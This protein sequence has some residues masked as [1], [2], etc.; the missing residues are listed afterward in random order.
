M[1]H[2]LP[3][4]IGRPHYRQTQ[5]TVPERTEKQPTQP[6]YVLTTRGLQVVRA[7][8]EEMSGRADVDVQYFANKA[9]ELVA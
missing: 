7:T 9:L 4:T 6:R 2:Q 1:D 8:L 3:N 5:I